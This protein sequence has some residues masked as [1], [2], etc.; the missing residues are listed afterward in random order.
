MNNSNKRQCDSN[1]WQ[2]DSNKRQRDNNKRQCDNNEQSVIRWP[3]AWG[4][5]EQGR[6]EWGRTRYVYHTYFTNWILYSSPT[7]SAIEWT[8]P[9][10]LLPITTTSISKCAHESEPQWLRFGLF[11]PTCVIHARVIK[12]VPPPLAQSSTH[13]NHHHHHLC[14]WER[15]QIW[16]PAAQI[17]I[18]ALHAPSML[19]CAP[20][21]PPP[22]LPHPAD[23][24][25]CPQ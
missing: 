23:S 25:H 19:A 3:I 5:S 15:T 11:G 10:P 4:G 22:V 17:Q 24:H 21:T 9:P 13:P 14:F 8:P 12:C 20:I 16:A 6:Q 1:K 18:L 2:R 7:W